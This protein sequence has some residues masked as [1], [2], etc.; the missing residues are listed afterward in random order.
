[1]KGI[2]NER[3]FRVFV[4]NVTTADAEADVDDVAAAAA[5][6]QLKCNESGSI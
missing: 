1:M 3:I 6:V 5:D 4:V 2:K